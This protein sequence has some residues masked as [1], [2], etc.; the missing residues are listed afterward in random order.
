MLYQQKQYPFYNPVLVRISM[1]GGLTVNYVESL[2]Q[3][4][5]EFPHVHECYEIYYCLSG[6]Q[7]LYI[8]GA[9]NTLFS[10]H[11]AVIRPGIHHYTN[12]EPNMPK[13]YLVFVFAPPT[14]A[15]SKSKGDQAE[16]NFLSRILKYFEKNPY[17]VTKDRF[18]CDSIIYKMETE[19]EE[20][21]PG[22]EQM[23][24]ALYQEYLISIFRNLD[25]VEREKNTPSNT[26]LAIQITK[27]MHANY[28]KNLTIQDIADFFYISSRHVNRIFE[29][30]FGQSL[31][32]TLNIYRLN[33]AKN[34]LI[35][36]A[37]SVEKIASLV[38]FSSQKML[39]RLF[40]EMEGI[41]VSEYRAMHRTGSSA[42]KC[43]GA[44]APES[45]KNEKIE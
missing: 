19:I 30:Y 43:S 11:F 8:D 16:E 33:Y 27:Y 45:K 20:S 9:M 23:I 22:R 31:K 26:N 1:G 3:S 42:V 7:H 14:A 10:G 36:T 21:Y 15:A 6:E 25:P 2:D 44:E 38:G 37:Y 17:Y 12:Y 34:Y 39:Y 32:R 29:E 18:G 41:T 4:C 5:V 28:N 13:R 40:K 24:C 35:D